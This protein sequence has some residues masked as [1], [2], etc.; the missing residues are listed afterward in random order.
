MISRSLSGF[1]GRRI[2]G[3]RPVFDH[4]LRA[5]ALGQLLADQA[6]RDVGEASGAERDD[7]AD[8]LVGVGRLR[9]RYV[10]RQQHRQHNQNLPHY[11]NP[12]ENLPT[13]AS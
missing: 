1:L 6:H 4:D 10:D 8:W 2:T 13:P 11:A 9:N 5:G 3:A 12:L 7:D